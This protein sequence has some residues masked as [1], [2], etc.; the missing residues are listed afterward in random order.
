MTRKEAL[1]F[2]VSKYK[3]FKKIVFEIEKKNFT[4]RGTWHEDI[5][6]DL[7]IK[8]QEELEKVEDKPEDILKFLE[9][10]Y[11]GNTFN[12][13]TIVKNHYI[14]FLRKEK[15]YIAFDY[16][17]LNKNE[18]NKLIQQAK[19]YELKTNTIQEKINAYVETFYWFDKKL[20]NLYRYEFKQHR[21]Q[22]SKETKISQSTIYR[23]VR[24]CKV[25]IKSRLKK[26]YY[27]K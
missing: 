16:Y 12:I 14:D 4:V 24:R 22:M 27:E 8:I 6:Q 17:K 13:Y 21:M 7:F 26:Q 19:Q 11:N 1:E 15:K 3:T 18:R 20:F 10:Y 5:T 23:T 9:R 25:K 2:I